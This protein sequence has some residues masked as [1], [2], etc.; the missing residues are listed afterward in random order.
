MA[1][2]KST[3]SPQGTSLPHLDGE[4]NEFILNEGQTVT[5][6]DP[7]PLFSLQIM[8]VYDE[9]TA[10]LDSMNTEKTF[11][12]DYDDIDILCYKTRK[13]LKNILHT[14]IP[15]EVIDQTEQLICSQCIADFDD[16]ELFVNEWYQTFISSYNEYLK[17][18]TPPTFDTLRECVK[19]LKQSEHIENEVI[20]QAIAFDLNA[21]IIIDP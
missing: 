7:H 5:I 8:E 20:I 4:P 2:S 10:A 17:E 21:E 11:Y 3:E 9:L 18:E 15:R 12:N 16:F 13:A 19:D 1:T 14:D 6:E